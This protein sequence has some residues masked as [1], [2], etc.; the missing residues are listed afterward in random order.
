MRIFTALFA[1]LCFSGVVHAQQTGTPVSLDGHLQRQVMTAA[2]PQQAVVFQQLI[3]GEQYALTIPDDPSLAACRPTPASSDAGLK[4]VRLDAPANTL[5]FTATAAQ[6]TFLF[7]YPCQ[8]P[9][10][11]PPRHYVSLVCQTCKK[12]DLQEYLK[13][14]AVISVE[15]GYSAFELVQ[16]V[17]IGGNCFDISGLTYDGNGSAIGKFSNGL[18]NVGF[19]SGMIMATGDISVAVGPNTTDNASAGFGTGGADPDLS[20]IAKSSNLFDLANIEFDF[21]PTQTPV[22]FE[23]VF[24]SEEYCEFVGTQYNDAFGFFIDGPGISGP[25]SGAANLAQIPGTGINIT[26]NDVNHQSFSGLYVNNTG[27]GGILCGQGPSFS[28]AV[29]E[30][31]FDGYTR[32]FL[33]VANVIPCQ[34]Y[35]IKLKIADAGDSAYDSAVFLKAGSFDGGGSASV[36]FLVNDDPDDEDAYEGC[37]TAVL[38]FDRVGGNINVP[39]PVSFTVAGSAT[40]GADYSPIPTTV[41]IPAGQDKLTIPVN[42]VNDL[43]TEGD[44]DIVITLNNPCSCLNPQEI[45]IIKDLPVLTAVADTVTIC[46]PGAATVGVSVVEG[47]SPYTYLWQNGSTSETIDVFAA[48]STNYRVTVTDDCGKT[49][50]KTARVIVTP[51][52]TAQLLPPAPQLCPGGTATIVV[53][54]NGTGPFSLSYSI[55]G[56]TYDLYDITEDPYNLVIDETGLYTVVSVTDSAGCVGPGQGSL[57]I[58]ES[59]LSV[60]GVVTNAPCAGLPSGSINTTVTGGRPIHTYEWSGPQPV[61][62]GPDPTGLVPG[63][64]FLTVTDD[65]GC[66]QIDTFNV[67]APAPLNTT[68]SGVQVANCTNPTGGSINLSVS[69]G[70]PTYGYN[71]NNGSNV[72]DPQNL[73][74]GTYAVTVTDNNGCTGTITADVPGDFAPPTAV[75]APTPPLTCTV[76]SVG[77]DGSGSNS[78][79]GYTT[80]WTAGPGNIVSGANTLNPVVN[81]AGNYVLTVTSTGNG[82]TATT[83]VTVAADQT[84]PTANAGPDQAF[85][86]VV[87]SISLN[88]GGSSQGP[89]FTYA[90]TPSNGGVILNGANSATPQIG[91]TGQYTLLVTNTDNGCTRTD[92]AVIGVDTVAPNAV[93]APPGTLTCTV[94][95]LTLSGA[96]STPSGNLAFAWSTTTGNILSG[97]NTPSPVIGEP[98]TY[99]LLVTNNTNGCTDAANITVTQSADVPAAT[100][101]PP[102]TLTCTTTQQTLNGNG[103]SAGPTIQ[104][105]WGA[106]PG[107]NIVSGAN[108]L[109]PVVDAPG[110]YVLT[111]TNTANSCSATNTVQVEENVDA[112][113]I[114]AGTDQVLSCTT[115]QIQL[116]GSVNQ[117]SGGYTYLWAG[118]GILSGANT[119]TPV[120]NSTGA[121]NLTVTDLLNGCTSTDVVAITEDVN[122]P[123]AAA[124]PAG[125]LTCTVTQLTLNALASSTGSNFTYAWSGPALVSGQ[126]SLQPVINQPGTYTL[127]IT[128]TDNGCIDTLSLNIGQDIIPPPADAGPDDVLN[129][130]QPQLPIGGPGNPSGP[131]YTFA[132]D[133]PGAAGG[134]TTPA[135]LA[136]QGGTYTL[137][138]T[139]TVNG[140]TTIDD[141]LLSTDFVPP[142]AN[143]GPGFELDCV[144]ETYTLAATA[145]QGPNFTYLWTTQNGNFTTPADVL[146]PTVNGAGVYSLTVTNT[147]NGCTS[148]ANVT[149][150]Q[151]ADVP[152]A[153]AGSAPALTCALTQVQL[154]AGGSS[155]GPNILYVWSTGDGNIVGGDNTLTPTVDA[156]GTYILTVLDATNNCDAVSSVVVDEDVE[157]PTVSAGPSPILTCTQPSATLQGSVAQGGTY[158]YLWQPSAGGNITGGA[159]T[160]IP[161]VDAGGTYA[162]LVT[163]QVNGCTN[164]ASV[165]VLVNQIDPVAA[166]QNP[167]TLTC[168][169]TQVPL[170]ASASSAGGMDYVWATTGGNIVDQSNPLQPVV[171]QPGAYTLLVTDPVNGC[172]ASANV[173]VGQDVT[174]PV[175]QAVVNG[176]LTCTVQS[177]I[178]NGGGSSQ[179]TPYAYSWSTQNGVIVTGAT[180]LSPTVAGAGVYLLQVLNTLNGCASTVQLNVSVDTLAPLASIAPPAVLS[181]VQPQTSLVGSSSQTG[182]NISYQ[183]T[184]ANG[185]IVGGQNSP[186]ALVGATGQYTL[187]VTNTTTGCSSTATTNVLDDIELPLADAGAPQ[188]LTCTVDEVTLSGSASTGANFTYAWSTTDGQI[189]SGANTLTPAVSEP[190]TYT[191]L[192]TNTNTGCTQTAEVV[193]TEEDNLPTD[194]AYVMLRP[195]CKD[196]DGV[197]QFGA[198][199]GGFEPYLYS[200]DGGATFTSEPEFS[201]LPPGTYALVIQDANGCEHDQ[202]LVVPKAPDPGVD[203]VPQLTISLGEQITLNAALPPGYPVA[204]IDTVIWSPMDGL[205]FK[206]SSI[207]DL[208]RPTASPIKYTEYSVTVISGDDCEATDRVRI[209]VDNEPKIYIPNAFNPNSADGQNNKFM[210]FAKTEQIRQVNAFQVY[211]RW[212]ERVFEDF[213]FQPNDPAHG[214]DGFLDGKLLNPAVF[215]Y[216]AEIE[217]IDGRVL[218]F[219]GDVSLLQ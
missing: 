87:D 105:S 140:C 138:V 95:N 209:L 73:A 3:P 49:T 24:A 156:P 110:T 202:T 142:A 175:A 218:L 181:C 153:L 215:V 171:D 40:P 65:F 37:E 203:L 72:Q 154:N 90:W 184:T 9:A 16:E 176:I 118:P 123:V 52:P 74:P 113:A 104:Y 189:V 71:W 85:T 169:T 164:T 212:G 57:F 92:V 55:N 79:P 112:P 180:T 68:I 172:T 130:Y 63:Q 25:F 159:N 185:S 194:F 174:P 122:A 30:L 198:V 149:I 70:T 135:P 131:G 89:N 66:T 39:L 141:V 210:I 217:L 69:G 34:T 161:T 101:A 208:L 168:V 151:S 28:A 139:N 67:G 191:L 64:Y 59:T 162:L 146:N 94:K 201:N 12:T 116:S 44:E 144:V 136:D 133:G 150:T 36:E 15:S 114:D 206:S 45:L 190:G 103:S 84:L 29:N 197:I 56:N 82:C 193:V 157:Q 165:D 147:T 107:A 80:I 11:N 32:R 163:N 51:P 8:W 93:I 23:Y 173:L 167:A 1:L 81:Q 188:L 126:G 207:P 129:C 192:V 19:E 4:D 211:D 61:S 120:V 213:D 109:N 22:T 14:L 97:N 143:A 7:S 137:T 54:F 121:Y 38:R 124:Q 77:I 13:S 27:P 31:Q 199:T 62:N 48:G 158:T 214:W 132:W 83:A 43:I 186:V 86:C 177:L 6:H 46:G 183:W 75:A 102:V 200:I 119:L 41:I 204:L 50:V 26:I 178:L 53:N 111:V 78:G 179:G 96:G 205:T 125:P 145:S 195:T 152:V 10:D 106:G 47:V 60:S 148:S 20:I 219:K 170:D 18:T 99:T 35:H 115:P 187:Q 166:I 160:L 98:G 33:A 182:A 127:E 76:L 91:N 58:V 108:T 21:T 117:G 216:Y 2:Q 17:L 42:I 196:N 100:V 134:A 88:G 5:Y 155:A 128:N